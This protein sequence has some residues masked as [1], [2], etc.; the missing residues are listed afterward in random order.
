VHLENI[1]PEDRIIWLAPGETILAHTNE[2]IG[3]RGTVT[4]MMKVIQHSLQFSILRIRSRLVAHGAATLLKSA[5]AQAGATSVTSTDGRWK[6]LITLNTTPFPLWLVGVSLK[7][8]SSSVK[9]LWISPTK[10]MGSIKRVPLLRSCRA[11]G[12]RLICFQSSIK[13]ERS[14]WLGLP[15]QPHLHQ[16]RLQSDRQRNF[17]MY[18]FEKT[19]TCFFN[20]LSERSIVCCLFQ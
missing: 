17:A 8:F 20:V 2:Y 5:S 14:L 6:S 9:A 13:T 18:F 19:D 4:T 16:H 12:N 7:L 10:Q 1:F 11:D 15:P 3:G